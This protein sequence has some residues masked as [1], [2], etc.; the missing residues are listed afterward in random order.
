MKKSQVYKWH[1]H[2]HKGC[3]NTEDNPSFSSLMP[4]PGVRKTFSAFIKLSE[5]IDNCEQ[6][7]LYG[8]SSPPMTCCQK[9]QIRKQAENNWVLLYGNSS[10]HQSLLIQNYLAKNNIVALQHLFHL[11]DIAPTDFH[12]FPQL[13]MKLKG[14]I[15]QIQRTLS[16][17]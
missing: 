4:L 12:P 3:I 17:M 9:E 11:P 13:K 1:K 5:Q 2:F 15:L 14:S 16:N 7:N 10:A 6:N 8:Y